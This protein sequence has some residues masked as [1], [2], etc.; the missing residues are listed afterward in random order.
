MDEGITSKSRE[1]DEAYL[2]KLPKGYKFKPQDFELIVYLKRKVEKK[3]LPPNKIW[4]VQLYNYDP[5]TLTV[6]NNNESSNGVDKEWHYF[7]PRDRKH[8]NGSRPDRRAGEGYWKAT[9]ADKPIK[10]KGELVGFKKT[11]VFYWGKPSKSQK[12][13]WI[14]HEYVLSDHTPARERTSSTGDMRLNDWVLCRIYKKQN[15]AKSKLEATLKVMDTDQKQE[16]AE[17]A[18][19]LVHTENQKQDCEISPNPQVDQQTSSMPFHYNAN[20]SAST[21]EGL[22]HV[23]ETAYGSSST[24]GELP[25]FPGMPVIEWPQFFL[26]FY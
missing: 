25:Q 6:S 14:M 20:G 3:P 19:S 11:L 1:E 4:E 13:N 24:S 15:D 23:A 26:Y 10:Y 7:T 9:I 18:I 5:D 8:L 22:P 2:K 12:T 21:S 17:V 16:E